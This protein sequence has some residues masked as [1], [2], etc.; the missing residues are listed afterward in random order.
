MSVDISK[1]FYNLFD[2][3]PTLTGS[4][5][6]FYDLGSKEYLANIIIER[7]LNGQ[8]AYPL[9]FR[10]MPDGYKVRE[11]ESKGRFE[12]VLAH[13]TELDWYSDQRYDKVFR[14]VL[15]PYLELIRQS[16]EGANGIYLKRDQ[17]GFWADVKEYPNYGFQYTEDNRKETQPNQIDFWDAISF[18]V[19]L[20]IM[21]GCSYAD[22]QYTMPVIT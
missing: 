12:F 16:F 14:K 19:D 10:L 13:N 22:I 15:F 17:D 11:D 5:K 6:L 8:N 2:N 9:L 7:Q 21:E 18:S 3:I 4:D 20:E 1:V